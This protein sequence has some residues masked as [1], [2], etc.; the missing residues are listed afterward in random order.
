MKQDILVVGQR[1]GTKYLLRRTIQGVATPIP[2]YEIAADGRVRELGKLNPVGD[3]GFYFAAEESRHSAYFA[4]LPYFLNDLRPGGFLGRLVPRRYPSWGFPPDT[5]LWSADDTIRF[6]YNVGSDLIG[7]LVVGETLLG[8]SLRKPRS[9]PLRDLDQEADNVLDL[10]PAGSSAQGEQPKFLIRSNDQHLLVKFI[11]NH[12]DPVSVRGRDLLCAERLAL[13][14]YYGDRPPYEAKIIRSPSRTFLV[15]SRFDRIK[16]GAVWGRRG[17]ITLESID[18]Q[19]VGAGGSWSRIAK[20]LLENGV[21]SEGAAR[22]ICRRELFG[23]FI[24]NN[25]MHNS[26]CSLMLENL[27]VGEPAPMYDMLPMR[28]AAVTGQIRSEPVAIPTPLPSN[29]TLWDEVAQLARKF[30]Q[31]VADGTEFSNSFRA[32]ARQNL[33]EIKQSAKTRSRVE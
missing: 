21:L 11:S 7:S 16:H 8:E 32:I 17:L 14:A 3:R 29:L 25:D 24:G 12:S 20:R 26:N 19:F 6:L 22:E 31:D 18:Q 27:S 15:L 5:R 23:Q 13:F 10:G 4:D 33:R 2:I 30:W 28:Y 9:T 1:R